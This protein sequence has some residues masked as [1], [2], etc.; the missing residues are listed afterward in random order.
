MPF[1]PFLQARCYTSGQFPSLTAHIVDVQKS[2][3]CFQACAEVGVGDTSL[4]TGM[5]SFP[6][7]AVCIK[8]SNYYDC[9]YVSCLPCLEKVA[10]ICRYS[11]DGSDVRLAGERGACQGR[12]EYLCL[13][14]SRSILAAHSACTPKDTIASQVA[15]TRSHRKRNIFYTLPH[16]QSIDGYKLSDL[17]IVILTTRPLHT[18][19]DH[20]IGQKFSL[21]SKSEIRYV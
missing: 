17:I 1:G 7:H 18:T 12:Y 14:A 11:H 15:A 3:A 4:P 8:K 21:I 16:T 6:P 19:M 2:S 20:L 9:P 10:C 5:L 13:A